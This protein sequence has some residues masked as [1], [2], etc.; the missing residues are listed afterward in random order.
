MLLYPHSAEG[1]EAR[2][3][4]LAKQVTDSKKR[5]VADRDVVALDVVADL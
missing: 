3:L 1:S 4:Q 2:N 5:L